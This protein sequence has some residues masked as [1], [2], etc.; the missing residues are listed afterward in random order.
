NY[1]MYWDANNLY[2]WAMSQSL[3]LYYL[4]FEEG[5]SLN[6]ILKTPD[7]SHKGYIVEVDLEFPQRLHDKFK[8]FPPA[9]KSLTPKLDW[10]SDFQK[11]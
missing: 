9:P 2:G 11:I 7:D 4:R 10:F 8:E 6:K 5:T 3:P 1:L